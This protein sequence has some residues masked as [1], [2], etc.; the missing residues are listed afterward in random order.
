MV[1]MSSIVVN[2]PINIQGVLVI[3]SLGIYPD[4]AQL[5]TDG[6]DAAIVTKQVKIK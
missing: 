4:K 2:Y 3:N 5:I 6:F 1:G